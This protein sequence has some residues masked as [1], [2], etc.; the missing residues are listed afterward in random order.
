MCYVFLFFP[1][2]SSLGEEFSKRLSSPLGRIMLSRA[3]VEKA[4]S[5]SCT[6]V[7]TGSYHISRVRARKHLELIALGLWQESW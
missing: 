5:C 7:D 4:Q 1:S 6:T 2:V 3:L